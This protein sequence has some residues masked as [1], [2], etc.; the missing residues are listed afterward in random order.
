MTPFAKVAANLNPILSSIASSTQSA[1]LKDAWSAF[2]TLHCGAYP[3][4]VESAAG[5]REARSARIRSAILQADA[6]LPSSLSR[7]DRAKIIHDRLRKN[8]RFYGLPR[9]PRLPTVRRYV[10]ALLDSERQARAGR[11]AA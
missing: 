3:G 5:A 11:L 8:A 7:P 6:A 9:G 4:R 1:E 2:M 10:D